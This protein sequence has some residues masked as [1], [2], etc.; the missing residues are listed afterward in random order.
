MPRVEVHEVVFDAAVDDL[1]VILCPDS[2]CC[3]ANF[4]WFVQAFTE[5]DP[6]FCPCCGSKLP[7][8]KVIR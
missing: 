2:G 1:Y 5:E 6:K 3:E 7:A 8:A 4:P